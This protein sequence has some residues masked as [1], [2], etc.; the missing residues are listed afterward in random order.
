MHLKCELANPMATSKFGRLFPVWDHLL[1]PLPFERLVVFRGPAVGD[2]VRHS[3]GG[4]AAGTTRESDNDFDAHA[5][6]KHDRTAKVLGVALR[7]CL[8]R[9]HRVAVT[10]QRHDA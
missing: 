5:L 6:G 3:I 1:L 10:T 9:M 2:P 7:D 8:I 4:A